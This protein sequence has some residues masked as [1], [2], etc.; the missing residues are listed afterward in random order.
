MNLSFR[1]KIIGLFLIIGLLPIC[2]ISFLS[3][4]SARQ[5]IFD[6]VAGEV[7]ARAH[8]QR[9]DLDAQISER[10]SDSILWANL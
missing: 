9:S 8:A 3:Y 4:Q 1:A 2:L 6:M 5:I 7:L 10:V